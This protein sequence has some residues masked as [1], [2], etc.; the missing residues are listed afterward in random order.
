ME[1]II[2][3][4]QQRVAALTLGAPPPPLGVCAV[5]DGPTE[6]DAFLCD[7]CLKDDSFKAGERSHAQP[8]PQPPQEFLPVPTRTDAPST[9]P[10]RT[11]TH[12]SAGRCEYCKPHLFCFEH[13]NSMGKHSEKYTCIQCRDGMCD[14]GIL[15][16]DCDFCRSSRFCKHNTRRSI[17]KQGCGGKSICEPKRERFKCE[18]CNSDKLC[19][20]QE[21]PS[22]CKRCKR[23]KAIEGAVRNSGL[24]VSLG[25]HC[26]I[27]GKEYDNETPFA[28]DDLC[29][30][31]NSTSLEPDPEYWNEFQKNFHPPP[32]GLPSG[33]GLKAR[34]ICPHQIQKRGCRECSP[35]LFCVHNRP[36]N[37]C[38]DC[39]GRGFCIHDNI[40]TR[41][42]EC[43]GS[44]ICTHKKRR[45]NCTICQPHRLC[46]HDIFRQKC[47]ICKK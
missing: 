2:C 20:H 35:H 9:I 14:H 32:A 18:E 22:Q 29:D 28:S 23:I 41:C 6:P 31:C 17:C 10:Q 45:D 42:V 43:G 8:E 1:K 19:E 40:R 34:D 33:S 5:C 44:Q 16:R 13:T 47:R 7:K 11:C 4:L 36:R 30:A 37:R 21:I 24:G 46:E 27:C 12:S 26:Q 38:K 3:L 39:G 25:A 15:R